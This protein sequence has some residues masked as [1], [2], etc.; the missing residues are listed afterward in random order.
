MISQETIV[1]PSESSLDASLFQAI[2][3]IIFSVFWKFPISVAMRSSLL[4]H[5]IWN[6]EKVQCLL[7][8]ASVGCT[9]FQEMPACAIDDAFTPV[10]LAF[11]ALRLRVCVEKFKQLCCPCPESFSW[12]SYWTGCR[13]CF[14]V[15]LVEEIVGEGGSRSSWPIHEHESSQL[16]SQ[17]NNRMW[18]SR[19]SEVNVHL[20]QHWLL[21]TWLVPCV[22]ADNGFPHSIMICF[23]S[24]VEVCAFM[25]GTC[26]GSSWLVTCVTA[27][28]GYPLSIMCC[29]IFNVEALAVIRWTCLGGSWLVICV[30][31]DNG[32]PRSIMDNSFFMKTTCFDLLGTGRFSCT[33]RGPWVAP[34]NGSHHSIMIWIG[35][36]WVSWKL[37]AF[38]TTSPSGCRATSE[39]NSFIQSCFKEIFGGSRGDAN[40]FSYMTSP[41]SILTTFGIQ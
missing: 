32:C 17:Q 13:L 15:D 12:T 11:F 28:N 27:D 19:Y 2:G 7:D 5:V 9:F 23:V 16:V 6:R 1:N 24:N 20:L 36:G 30:T 21:V 31:A 26:L 25:R 34:D 10:W 37:F 29:Y 41:V 4:N 18:Q 40:T 33:W 22:T 8:D 14:V 35:F 39:P 3:Q 38:R